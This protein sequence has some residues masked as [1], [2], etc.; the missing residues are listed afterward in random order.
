MTVLVRSGGDVARLATPL[1][2]AVAGLDPELP[3]ARL[4][5]IQEIIEMERVGMNAFAVLF[6]AGALFFA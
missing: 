5:T 3:V 1:R 6:V 4:Q 2:R